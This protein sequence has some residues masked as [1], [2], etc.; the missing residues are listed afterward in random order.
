MLRVH[1]GLIRLACFT[2]MVACSDVTPRDPN[3]PLL[4]APKPGEILDN[5]CRSFADSMIWVFD[6]TDVPNASD[7]HIWVKHPTAAVPLLDNSIGPTS[8][9]RQASL[10]WTA[11]G[12]G[13]EW[14]V[15]AVVDGELKPWSEIRIFHVEQLDTDCP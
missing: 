2:T 9:H 8:S 7:Y 3:V 14:K 12:T 4:L 6:W 1:A 5:G 13:W 15:R 11:W 10:A